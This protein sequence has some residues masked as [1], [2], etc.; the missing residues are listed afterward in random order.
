MGLPMNPKDEVV[1][2][3]REA[4]AA[5]KNACRMNVLVPGEGDTKPLQIGERVWVH[6]E[7]AEQ[8][9]DYRL[10]KPNLGPFLVTELTKT[11]SV[12]VKR[13]DRRS[14]APSE[15]TVSIGKVTRVLTDKE[16]QDWGTAEV[17][18][19]N[20][21]HSLIESEPEPEAQKAGRCSLRQRPPR[22]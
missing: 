13:V 15:M 19:T 1:K 6:S 4:T 11:G 3:C 16:E 8:A 17:R 7:Q 5:Y 2:I 21:H 14:E 18:Y 12:K 20:G 22:T 10:C 9:P